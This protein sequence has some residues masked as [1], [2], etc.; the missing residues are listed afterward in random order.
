MSLDNLY[1]LYEQSDNIDRAEGRLAYARYRQTMV[2]FADH[3]DFPLKDVT[4]AFVALSPNNDYWGNLRSLASVLAGVRDGRPVDEV[5]VT[6][7]NACRDRAIGYLTGERNFLKTVKGPKIRAFRD[8]ILRPH[9]SRHV[10]VDGHMIAAWHDKRLTMKEA[11]RLLKGRAAY[12]AIERDIQQL[13]DNEGFA[14]CQM[15]AVL[16]FTRKRLNRVIYDPQ[17]SLFQEGDQWGT[18]VDP[19]KCPPYVKQK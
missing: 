7:F 5:V 3:Y 13:A 2:A 16:W 19:R 15:Q 4:S 18:L 12:T 17:L 6:T 14:P 11:Q 9:S 10:T 1:K 8:N